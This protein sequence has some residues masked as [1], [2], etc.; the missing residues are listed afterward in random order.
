MT[1][2]GKIRAREHAEELCAITG[3]VRHRT[4]VAFSVGDWVRAADTIG[5]SFREAAL[6][7]A[8]ADGTW[9]P[10]ASVNTLRQRLLVASRIVLAAGT[11]PTSFAVI[12]RELAELTAVHARNDDE[13]LYPPPVEA[14]HI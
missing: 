1:S 13:E 3:V 14:A 9:G 5:L 11:P 8:A 12:D 10:E 7:L 2:D 4:G 6:V